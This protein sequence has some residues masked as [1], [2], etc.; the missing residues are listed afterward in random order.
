MQPLLRAE[1]K[2]G[3]SLAF[4]YSC[5]P[6]NFFR[7]VSM[8]PSVYIQRLCSI[9]SCVSSGNTISSIVHVALTQ[10]LYEADRL[11]EVD[12]AIVVAVHEAALATSMCR[13]RRSPTT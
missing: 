4:P 6:R 7:N 10:Q 5:L 1:R 11:R 9:D 8:R 2:I 3:A 12:V 13:S